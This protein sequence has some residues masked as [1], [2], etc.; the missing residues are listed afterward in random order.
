MLRQNKQ[1]KEAEIQQVV[2][3]K[4]AGKRLLEQVAASNAEQIELKR[5]E[6]DKEVEEEQRIAMYLREKEM[7]DQKRMQE[8]EAIKAS[9]FPPFPI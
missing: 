7:R 8:E 3:K 4:E 6:K 1:M 2:Q 5:R 9:A